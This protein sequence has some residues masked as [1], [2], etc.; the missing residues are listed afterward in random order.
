MRQ[1]QVLGVV[2]FGGVLGAQARYGI[3]LAL[4]SGAG[5]PWA[6]LIVNAA[7]CLLI[8]ALMTVL[9]ELTAPH[10]LA[11]PFLG[12]G[13]LGGFTTFSGYAV[14][15]QALL[16]DGRP[17]VAAAFWVVMPVVAL[18]SVWAGARLTRMV[19]TRRGEGGQP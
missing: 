3:E 9:L 1:L 13:V 15:V 11:R 18:A 19:V 5:M 17:A 14:G 16:V 7:G 6:T 4:P 8:G 10:R 12:V 2:A